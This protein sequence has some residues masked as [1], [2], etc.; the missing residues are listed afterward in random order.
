M[1]YQIC[2]PIHSWPFAVSWPSRSQPFGTDAWEDV[3][4]HSTALKAIGLTLVFTLSTGAANSARNDICPGKAP[5]PSGTTVTRDWTAYPAVV[6]RKTSAN[7]FAIGDPHG[8]PNRLAKV[9]MAAG[10]IENI[11]MPPYEDVMWTGSNSI[12][13]ITGDLIDKGC[14]SKGVIDLVVAL[15]DDAQKKGGEVIVTMGNHEAR[16]LAHPKITKETCKEGLENGQFANELGA[17]ATNVARCEGQSEDTKK[18]G[19]FLCGLPIAA[20]VNDW[21]FSHGGNTCAR[22]IS[23][24]STD[25]SNDFNR[26]IDSSKTKGFATEQLMG[27]N[28]ILEARLNSRGPGG[29]PWIFNGNSKSNPE[30]SYL[31]DITDALSKPN[32]VNHIVQGH[33]PE[34]VKFGVN[35]K[36]FNFFQGYQ[37]KLF[38]IDTGMSNGIPKSNS[39]GGALHITTT[40]DATVIC[41]DGPKGKEE[42]IWIKG[43]N[44]G[45]VQVQCDRN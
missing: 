19:K 44:N 2:T 16:F 27:E 40:G 12:L 4:T 39:A 38:L 1:R 36:A 20:R 34:A 13:I 8:D 30:S 5:R 3:V 24:L 9:L 22:T 42:P 18:Y 29:Y 6:E 33:Q 14:N 28:S 17:E 21:F 45:S 37:G 7:I 25:V 41:A 11:P 10:L 23:T 43:K 32:P 15:K 26:H 31:R 35:R